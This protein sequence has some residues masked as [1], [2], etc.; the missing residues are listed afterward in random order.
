M[1]LEIR[2]DWI[3]AEQFGGRL[4]CLKKCNEVEIKGKLI[5]GGARPK[6]ISNPNGK[7]ES[8]L[9]TNFKRLLLKGERKGLSASQAT[10]SIL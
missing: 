9:L 5:L 10:L 6:D 1:D 4:L 3:Y 7:L 2:E 8:E